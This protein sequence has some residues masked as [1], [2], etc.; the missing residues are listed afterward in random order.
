MWQVSKLNEMY[1]E[2]KG[3]KNV[4]KTLL[5]TNALVPITVYLSV[6]VTPKM[7]NDG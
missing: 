4:N 5:K 6:S 2:V 7:P 3:F 1:L